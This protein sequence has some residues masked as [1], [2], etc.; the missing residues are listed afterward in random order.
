MVVV[1]SLA[2]GSEGGNDLTV[3]L[4]NPGVASSP[5]SVTVNGNDIVVNLTDAAGLLSSTA[6]RSSPRSMPAR[7]HSST[8]SPIAA[9]PG[10]GSSRPPRNAR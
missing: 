1:S 9:T 7:V 2:Y 3:E 8:R 4:R 6:P 10:P 5:L